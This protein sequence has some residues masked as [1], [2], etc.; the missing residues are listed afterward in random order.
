M[1]FRKCTSF[2]D[3]PSTNM[4][5]LNFVN[6]VHAIPRLEEQEGADDQFAAT[7]VD[8]DIREVY[9]LIMRFLSTGPCHKTFTQILDELLEHELLPRRYHAWYSRSGAQSG[10]KNDDGISFPLNYDNLVRR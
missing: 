4:A 2:S 7:N 5:P 1:D 3:A 10:D 6:K 9:F 8:V